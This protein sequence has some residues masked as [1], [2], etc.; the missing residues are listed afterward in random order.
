MGVVSEAEIA[1][2]CVNSR[3]AIE[4]RTMLW[5]IGH[6]Q[7]ATP[8]ELDNTTAHGVIMKQLLPRRSKAIDIR[9]Y[10]LRDRENQN[11][12]NM[13]WSKG[14]NNLTDYFT[15]HHS[16][17]HHKRMRKV[18]MS[19]NLITTIS[20]NEISEFLQGCVDR[21]LPACVM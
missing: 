11:Q 8:L 18:Y 4:T 14:E 9:H 2:G 6:L 7:L 15:K 16:V 10:Q 19:S 13:H 5:E 12:F 20:L 3:D 1:G 17:A 21:K